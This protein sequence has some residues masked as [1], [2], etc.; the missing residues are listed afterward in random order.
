MGKFLTI[1]GFLG[2]CVFGIKK[3]KNKV[4]EFILSSIL[5]CII[6]Y[7][8]GYVFGKFSAHI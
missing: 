2:F 4:E 1:I 7:Y 3:S 5:V 6:V 8:I